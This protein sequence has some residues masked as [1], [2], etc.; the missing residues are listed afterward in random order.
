MTPVK[1]LAVC[2]LTF[3]SSTAVSHAVAAMVTCCL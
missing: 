2:I 3:M 1:R